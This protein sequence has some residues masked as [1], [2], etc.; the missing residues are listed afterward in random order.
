[1]SQVIPIAILVSAAAMSRLDQR[2]AP[3]AGIRAE[4][5]TVE[6]RVA[7]CA[8]GTRGTASEGAVIGGSTA[9]PVWLTATMQSKKNGALRARDA[10]LPR[11]PRAH[12]NPLECHL[13]KCPPQE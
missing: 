11:S 3:S 13:R 2:P 7:A 9:K 5:S 10:R 8:P 4:D 12:K 6:T 1:M